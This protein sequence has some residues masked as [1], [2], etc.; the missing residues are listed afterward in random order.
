MSPPFDAGFESLATIEEVG[1]NVKNYKKG[2]SV[3]VT[4]FG[5]FSEYQYI[6]ENKCVKVPSPDPSFLPLLVSGLTASLAL[7]CVG[8]ISSNQTVLVTAAAGATGSFAVQLAK[9]KGNHVI[10]TCSSDDKVAF[11]KSLG[12]DRVI[13]YKKEDLDSVLSNEYPKGVNLVYE[14][15][16]GDT[17]ETCVNHLAI[18]GTLIV[19]GMISSYQDQSAWAASDIV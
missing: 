18:K 3:A 7:E 1:K 8:N 13:N 9:L 15:V 16:G 17:Y 2:D 5:A 6:K 19:I 4:S 12:C 14:S 10:G 11:L